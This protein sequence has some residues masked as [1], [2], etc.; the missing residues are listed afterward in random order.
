MAPPPEQTSNKSKE[1]PLGENRGFDLKNIFFRFEE[2]SRLANI[3]PKFFSLTTMAMNTDITTDMDYQHAI[4][5]NSGNST[6]ERPIGP[7]PCARLEATKAD[8]Q[9]Y[10]LIAQGFENM[11]TTLRQ[12]NAQDEDD[13]TFVEMLSKRA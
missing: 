7:T 1:T 3:E 9:R 6:P 4:L 12:S 8:I 10:T 5:P 2:L 13:P 11:L